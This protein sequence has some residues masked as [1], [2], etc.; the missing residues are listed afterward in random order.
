M[1][2]QYLLGIARIYA[3]LYEEIKGGNEVKGR[4]GLR[5][6]VKTTKVVRKART[7]GKLLESFVVRLVWWQLPPVRESGRLEFLPVLM[8]TV[9]NPC[10]LEAVESYIKGLATAIKSTQ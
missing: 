4:A 7:N 1:F 10:C 3:R 6:C 9:I 8:A 5:A 2:T